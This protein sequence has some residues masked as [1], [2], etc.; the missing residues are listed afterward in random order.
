MTP[1]Q[2]DFFTILPSSVRYDSNLSDFAKVLFSEIL[3]LS[4]KNGF[5]W[6]TNEHFAKA[7]SKHE[8]TI[9]RGISELKNAKYIEVL[10]T[11]T[12]LGTS[13]NLKP[14]SENAKWG[15]SKNAIPPHSKNDNTLLSENAMRGD[16]KNANLNRVK[17]NKEN[18]IDKKE[19]SKK[20]TPPQNSEFEDLKKQ[21]LA[22]KA[23]LEALEAEKEKEKK[24]AAKKEKGKHEFPK[25]K[26]K[27]KAE[28]KTPP[29]KTD[30]EQAKYKA[31]SQNKKPYEIA[32]Q[33]YHFNNWSENLKAAF[34]DFCAAR[35]EKQEGKFYGTQAKETIK[36]IEADV[37]TNGADRVGKCLKLCSLNGWTYKISYQINQES[38]DKEDE[39]KR[40][41]QQADDPSISTAELAVRQR[42]GENSGNA[43]HQEGYNSTG[44]KW[45]EYHQP[46][47]EQEF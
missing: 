24:I 18:L 36:T 9:S 7:F 21:L 37:L 3:A 30:I 46:D 41:K 20:G 38:R 1:E 10:I 43:E 14:L 12:A 23:K 33:D 35:Y 26:G 27:P 2:N 13:R 16:S 17:I 25:L 47:T 29:H 28:L 15:D 8:T 31:E 45:Y 22:T 44:L 6:A 4:K 11:I 5:C 32:I 40:K 34:Y 19:E 39:L 42:F